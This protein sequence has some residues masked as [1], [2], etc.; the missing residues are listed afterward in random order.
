MDTETGTVTPPDFAP[1]RFVH[2]TCDDIDINDNN[3]HGK[4]SFYATQIAGWQRGPEVDIGL[5]DLRPS[6]NTSLKVPEVMDQLPPAAMVIGS[7]EPRAT[8]VI[9]KERDNESND[10]YPSEAQ[11][12]AQKMA[13]FLKRQDMDI[14]TGWTHFNQSNCNANAILNKVTLYTKWLHTNCPGTSPRT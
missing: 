7:L 14:K 13:F 4:N 10:G 11:A 5:K 1:N 6:T 2:F 12:I 8:E 3:F 9:N